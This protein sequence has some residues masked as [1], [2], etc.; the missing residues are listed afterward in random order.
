L[1]EILDSIPDRKKL[2]RKIARLLGKYNQRQLEK[3][4]KLMGNS[5]SLAKIPPSFWTD[6]QLQLAAELIPFSEDVYLA[7]ANRLL[8]TVPI[9]VDWAL[10]NQ[11]AVDWASRYVGQLV[12]DISKS[13]ERAV[14]RAVSNFFAEEQTIG[15]LEKRLARMKDKFGVAFGPQRAEMI[16][17]TEITRAATQGELGVAARLKA[18]GIEMRKVWQTN[19]D[20]LV[21]PICEPLQSKEEQ[22]WRAVAPDGPPAHPRCRCGLSLLLPK[23]EKPND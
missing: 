22:D 20:D 23:P 6:S 14:G 3:L 21:C 18:E 11:D 19:K 13:T 17:V 8:E 12:K 10:V 2:E 5:P 9:G 16:A 1:A 7:S 4:L 15:D